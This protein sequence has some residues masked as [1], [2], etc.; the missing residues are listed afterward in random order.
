MGHQRLR[1]DES[2]QDRLRILGESVREN[3]NNTNTLV[4]LA[5]YI[6]EEADNRGEKVEPRREL[7][8]SRFQESREK[9]LQHAIQIAERALVLN[10][11]HVGA[12][13]QK[14]LAL[15]AL[16]QYNQADTLAD[17]ALNLAGNNPDALRLYAKFRALRAN[18]LS[19]EAAGLR[20]E[21]CSSSSHDDQRS[22]G[23]YR[24]TTTTCYPPSQQD[25]N[26]AAQL[27]AMAAELRR[28]A[29]AA[30]QTAAKVTKGTVDG[31]LILADLALWDGKTGEAQGYL[32]QAVN[33]DPKSLEA[34]D[35]LV[36]HYAQTGQQDKAEEQRLVAANLVHTTV[37]PLLR[38][39]WKRMEKMAWQGAK[40]FLARAYPI[41]PEDARIP[42][43][44]GVINEGDD[45]FD[46]AAAHYRVALA[47]EESRLQ[48]DELKGDAGSPLGRDA[49]EFGLA[50]QAR[51]H[52]A[53]LSEQTG[54]QAEALTH[55]HAVLGY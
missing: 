35:R 30:L 13:M 42:A 50:I 33:L 21:R 18:Q 2:Y 20:Q 23:V 29:K 22:D 54:R 7:Q 40:E 3:P 8:P 45:K 32:E 43:Y 10:A 5:T 36:Q 1:Y 46:E 24:V 14:A 19:N 28:R 49:L 11:K 55:Y 51:F 26:R 37:A 41:D 16:K 34:Q 9:D 39:A 38:Q 15:T 6:I 53:K 27:D 52:L 25:L 4:A 48:L 12:M 31:Y 17:Q 47:L 44:L